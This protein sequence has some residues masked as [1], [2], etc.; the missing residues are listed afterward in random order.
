MRGFRIIVVLAALLMPRG[1]IGSERP[2]IVYIIS[3]DQSW[4]DFG[5]MG[6]ER[7]HTP[8]L[9]RLA[10]RSAR[11]PNGY[12][13]TSV[14]RPS[15]ATLLTGLYPHQHGIHFNHGPP[16]NSGYNRMTSIE[17]Y[18]Q[19]RGRE[20]SL[21]RSV[22]TLPRILS[23]K[24]EYRVLQTGKFWEG[25]WRNGGFT[26]GMTTFETPPASQG[27][28]GVRTLVNGDRVAHG[29]GDHGLQIGRETMEPIETF[30]LDCEEAETPWM[31]WY[32]P[33]LPHQPHDAPEEFYEIAKSNPNVETHEIPYFAS[34]AQFDQTVGWLVHF[35][36][37]NA[38][39]R[40]TIFVFVSDN[41][42]RP[43]ETPESGR[44]QEFAHTKRSKRAPFD[45]GLRG[46]IL[47]RWDGVVTPEERSELVSSIDIVPTLLRLVGLGK[48][49]LPG[50]DLLKEAKTD[51]D[52]FGAVYPGDATS[53]GHPERDV[54][55]RWA[56]SGDWKL[57][58]PHGQN[59][60]GNYLKE[61]AL[62]NVRVDP[63][64]RV[65]RA[66]DDEYRDLVSALRKKIDAWWTP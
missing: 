56:R 64:E 12:L 7:V 21:I 50:H 36:E 16:G 14:C 61:P 38:D 4:S 15:L 5:F 3:D 51:R 57:I 53:L 62:F 58:L 54:A 37:V 49:D 27:Y 17:E 40:N 32:A 33:Y 65:N 63:R 23:E 22:E 29:N 31:V 1:G 11:F 47:L 42:W 9:D 10:A 19:V 59:P 48:N 43:S 20:F 55:Y 45:D 52:V 35:V 13:T 34:I 46:P 6:N 24:L 30:I 2:N 28:G 25:H 41:G 39:P 66:S 44:E 8:N 26:E 18:Q 60:W